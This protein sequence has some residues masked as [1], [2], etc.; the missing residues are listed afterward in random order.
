[1]CLLA[2]RWPAAFMAYL[3]GILMFVVAW[4]FSCPPDFSRFNVDRFRPQLVQRA[5]GRTLDN[6]P[7]WSTFV[8]RIG[9][10]LPQA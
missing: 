8:G 2:G 9:N 7:A 1:M 6:R 5:T 3:V 10:G 4:T